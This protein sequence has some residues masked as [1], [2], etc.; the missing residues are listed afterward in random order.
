MGRATQF[1]I[2][3]SLC[4]SVHFAPRF[5]TLGFDPLLVNGLQLIC[6]DITLCLAKLSAG[7]QFHQCRSSIL[8]GKVE[9]NL[10]GSGVLLEGLKE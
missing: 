10:G 3:I 7:Y 9:F 4:H 1:A 5:S 6:A 8:V 2:N